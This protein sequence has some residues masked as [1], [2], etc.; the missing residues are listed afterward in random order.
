MVGTK[1]NK[2]LLILLFLTSLLYCKVISVVQYNTTLRCING[3]TFNNATNSCKCIEGYRGETCQYKKCENSGMYINSTNTCMCSDDWRGNKCTMCETDNACHQLYSDMYSCEKNYALNDLNNLHAECS[4]QDEDIKNIIGSII[5]IQSSI[6]KDTGFG[7]MLTYGWKYTGDILEPTVFCNLKNC[8]VTAK[9]VSNG[10]LIDIITCNYTK[11]DCVGDTINGVCNK[12]IN[13]IIDSVHGKTIVTCL[14]YDE[15]HG[16]CKV[17]FS[18]LRWSIPIKCTSSRCTTV[19][20]KPKPIVNKY[21]IFN[22][23][24]TGVANSWKYY[25]IINGCLLIVFLSFLISTILTDCI[26]QIRATT[27]NKWINDNFPITISMENISCYF[28]KLSFPFTLIN[29]FRNYRFKDVSLKINKDKKDCHFHIIIGNNG[30]GKTLI[31]EAL[32]NVNIRGYRT[33]SIKF[34]GVLQKNIARILAVGYSDDKFNP[35]LTVKETL[36]FSYM[37][38]GLHSSKVD[39]NIR[40]MLRVFKLGKVADNKCSGLSKGQLKKLI[41]AN[42]VI[43]NRKILIIDEPTAA[44]ESNFCNQMLQELSSL[45]KTGKLVIVVAH[46]INNASYEL[47]DGVTLMANHKIVA[48]G[49]R[50]EV[51]SK[52]TSEYKNLSKSDEYT[53]VLNYLD[54]VSKDDELLDGD[55]ENNAL[56]NNSSTNDDKESLDIE[57]QE[58]DSLLKTKDDDIK[59]DIDQTIKNELDDEE[60]L[61]SKVKPP[62]NDNIESENYD[63]VTLDNEQE[64]DTDGGGKNAENNFTLMSKYSTTIFF[65]FNMLFRRDIKVLLRTKQIMWLQLLLYI[66]SAAIVSLISHDL[67]PNISGSQTRIGTISVMMIIIS[68]SSIGSVWRIRCEKDQFIKEVESGLYQPWIYLLSKILTDFIILRIIPTIVFCCLTYTSMGVFGDYWWIRVYKYLI[69]CIVFSQIALI[70]SCISLAISFAFDPPMIFTPIIN[71]LLLIVSL[72]NGV[73]INTSVVPPMFKWVYLISFVKYAAEALFINEFLHTKVI[74][75]LPDL[76][77]MNITIPIDGRF[78]LDRMGIDSSVMEVD[79]FILSMFFCAHLLILFPSFY[80][81]MKCKNRK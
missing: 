75:D 31:L 34:N 48:S 50:K 30:Q 58:K 7:G 40:T 37:M 24:I 60:V 54:H 66:I 44:V 46:N 63:E 11:C 71:I 53:H 18:S 56:I 79:I 14:N 47:F 80:F 51:Y 74:V 62:L 19:P 77:S 21:A 3:G 68:I 43:Q 27:Q 64:S 25:I 39:F 70:S 4:I 13:K 17:K 38:R 16:Q 8:S 9:T 5:E 45:S 65:Q 33:G 36:W 41:V 22:E 73:F 52:I 59:D 29:K 42:T 2:I 6:D 12:Y 55:D 67:Q 32:S 15:H 23:W 72:F 49:T 81:M 20:P 57:L 69:L 1:I 76:K 78:Y 61:T 10:H 28:T 26:Y 35:N